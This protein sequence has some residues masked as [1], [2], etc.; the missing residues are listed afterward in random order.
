MP[1]WLI[2]LLVGVVLVILGF[3]LGH[4]LLWIGVIVLVIALVFGLVGGRRGKV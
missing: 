3:P 4:L 2:I 1:A